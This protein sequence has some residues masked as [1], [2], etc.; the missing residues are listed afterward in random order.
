MKIILVLSLVL[1]SLN[2]SAQLFRAEVTDYAGLDSFPAVKSF[3]DQTVKN[4]QDDINDKIP[5]GAPHRV[6]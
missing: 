1:V 2:A 4:F 5:S 6:M 3:I